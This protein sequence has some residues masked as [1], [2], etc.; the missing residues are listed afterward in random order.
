MACNHGYIGLQCAFDGAKHSS[1]YDLRQFNV[2]K[3]QLLQ[4]HFEVKNALFEC[5]DVYAIDEEFDVVLNLGLLYHITDPYLL[6][7]KTYAS[8]RKFAVVD[9]ITHL[10]PVSAFIQRTNKDTQ[11]HAEGRF[12][13]EYHP[14]YRALID[15][16]HAVGFKDLVEVTPDEA[17]GS[18]QHPLYSAYQRRCLI[19]FK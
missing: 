1:G 11:H 4:T 3:A 8:C 5:K 19:G 10:A 13:V 17:P 16:M 18:A 7:A 12:A 6:M 15:L 9:T 2:E 14:T